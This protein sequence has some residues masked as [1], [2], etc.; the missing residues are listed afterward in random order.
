MRIQDLLLKEVSAVHLL[1][2]LT[3]GRS[4]CMAAKARHGSPLATDR[5]LG[6]RAS[7]TATWLDCPRPPH[8]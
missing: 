7:V 1:A 2:V 4:T 5:A 3:R 8:G 6:P